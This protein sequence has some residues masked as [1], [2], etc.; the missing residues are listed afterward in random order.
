MFKHRPSC[1]SELTLTSARM[2]IRKFHCGWVLFSGLQIAWFSGLEPYVRELIVKLSWFHFLQ[3]ITETE[4]NKRLQTL[5]KNDIGII[6]CY[7]LASLS[8]FA[9]IRGKP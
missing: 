4:F 2:Y 9:R 8:V 7:L 3:C 1:K 6:R 5:R